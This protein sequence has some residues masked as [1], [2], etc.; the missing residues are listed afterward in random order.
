MYFKHSKNILRN[1]F[2]RTCNRKEINRA[3]LVLNPVSNDFPPLI[4]TIAISLPPLSLQMKKNL[5]NTE[6]ET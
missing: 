5:E 6:Q 3:A 2:D 4:L 1:M